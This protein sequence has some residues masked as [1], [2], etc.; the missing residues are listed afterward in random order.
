MPKTDAWTL[1]QRDPVLRREL[2]VIEI[3]GYTPEEFTNAL[4]EFYQ[5]VD[6]LIKFSTLLV[7]EEL[8]AS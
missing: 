6:R 4:L 7:C 2:N 1:I 5:R 3:Q 8:Y